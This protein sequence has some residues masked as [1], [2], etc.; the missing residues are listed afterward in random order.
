MAGP[1]WSGSVRS[2]N[3]Q[4]GPSIPS[5]HLTKDLQMCVRPT[6]D[7]SVP[8]TDKCP[9]CKNQ[10]T[11]PVALPCGCTLCT[12][13]LQHPES[14]GKTVVCPQCS[15][16]FEQDEIRFSAERA[17]LVLKIRELETA[18]SSIMKNPNMKKLAVPLTL[19]EDTAHNLLS[20]SEDRKIV[21]YSLMTQNR[22][23]HAGRFVEALC[24]LGT[25]AFTSGRHYWEVE[26]GIEGDWDLGVCQ[27]SVE[28]HQTVRL[29]PHLGFWGIGLR[30]GRYLAH[31]EPPKEL[32]VKPGLRRLGIYLDVPFQSV[33]FLDA[34]DEDHIFTFTKISTIEKLRAFFL[35]PGE[36]P[37]S[38]LRICPVGRSEPAPETMTETGCACGHGNGGEQQRPPPSV[39]ASPASK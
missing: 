31:T 15:L 18:L 38:S 9:V 3:G 6:M 36:G 34:T 21:R 33:S 17:F 16:P 14:A 37:Q 20:V 7:K 25:P 12:Q 10:L 13:C 19:D 30:K 39:P 4:C 11:N 2:T 8:D 26:V 32:R 28:R 27:D 24:V 5:T 1:I 35:L 22:N 29:A 23:P